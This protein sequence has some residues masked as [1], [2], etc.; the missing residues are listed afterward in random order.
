MTERETIEKHHAD[1]WRR[2]IMDAG[3]TADIADRAV[4]LATLNGLFDLHRWSQAVQLAAWDRN[5]TNAALGQEIRDH[6][7]MVRQADKS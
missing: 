3:A 4:T 1:A 5:V 7:A 2:C 6:W